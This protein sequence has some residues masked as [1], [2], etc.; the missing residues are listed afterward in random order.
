VR[1]ITDGKIDPAGHEITR[2]LMGMAVLRQD[3]PLFESEF[4][5][6]CLFAV[7]QRLS[8]DLIQS[9]YIAVI[10]MLLEHGEL[11]SRQFTAR[12]IF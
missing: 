9:I 8:P 7:H 1:L 11:L 2:L 5:K 10:V 4:R 12:S 3:S 6:K